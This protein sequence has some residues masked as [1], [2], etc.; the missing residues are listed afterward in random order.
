MAF[1]LWLSAGYF[2]RPSEDCAAST[3]EHFKMLGTLMATA[4]RDKFVVPLHIVPY[5][6]AL[7]VGKAQDL[8]SVGK[9]IAA[10]KALGSEGV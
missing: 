5:F 4:T 8:A 6:F 9:K 1:R 10:V 7:V 2:P 3:L